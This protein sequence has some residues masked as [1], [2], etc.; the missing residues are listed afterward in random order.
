M[1]LLKIWYTAKSGEISYIY[2]RISL[3]NGEIEIFPEETFIE[4]S[5]K[6]LYA[7]D[8]VIVI[9]EIK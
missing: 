1:K 2:I 5:S 4:G 3:P 9:Q 6:E 7:E 8:F